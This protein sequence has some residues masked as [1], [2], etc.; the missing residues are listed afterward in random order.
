[1][2]GTGASALAAPFRGLAPFGESELDALLFFG[3][4]RETEVAVANLLAA[5]LTILY[6]PSGVGKSSLLR[7]GV[8]RRIRELSGHR[9][10]GRGPDGAAVV[11]ASW[12]DEPVQALADAIESEVTSL[13]KRPVAGPPPGT[14]L[15]DVVEHWSAVLDGRLYLVLDQLEEYFVYHEGGAGPGS[16]EQELPEVVLRSRL[17]A[18]VLLSLRDDALAQLDV[19][20]AQLPNL[21]AN[22]LRLDR[23]DHAAATAAILGPVKR[24]NELVPPGERWDVEPELV[25]DVLVQAAVTGEPDRIEPPYLQLVMERLWGEEHARGSR[26]LRASTLAELGGAGAIVREHLDRAM[27]VLGELEQ[28]AAAL[29][30][31]HLVTPSGTKVAHRAADLA[32]FAHVPRTEVDGLLAT[33]G[34]ERILRPLDDSAVGGDRYEIFHDVLG[35]AILGWRRRYQ[36]ASERSRARRRQRRLAAI[37]L[38]SLAAVLVMVGVTVYALT[39][40]AHARH[41]T[42]IALAETRLGQAAVQTAKHKTLEAQRE[43]AAAERNEKK[44]KK[45]DQRATSNLRVARQAQQKY[46]QQRNEAQGLATSLTAANKSLGAALTNVTSARD[47]AKQQRKIA[48]EKA[49]LADRATR[50]AQRQTGYAESQR[51]RAAARGS[52]ALAQADFDLDPAKSVTDALAAAR[53]LPSETVP[54]LR[55]ALVRLRLRRIIGRQTRSIHA[56]ALSPDSLRFVAAQGSDGAAVFD[57]RTGATIRRL[58]STG[59]VLVVAYAADGKTIAG[60]D[61]SG[62]TMLWDADSG[63]LLHTLPGTLPIAGLA[64]SNDGRLLATAG[65]DRTAKVWDVATGELRQELP[66]PNPVGSVAFSPDGSELLTTDRDRFARLFTL[67]SGRPPAILDQIGRVTSAQFSPDGSLIATTGLN[68][69]AVLWNGRTGEPVHTFTGHVS[70]VLDAAFSH[71]GTLLATASADN[72]ARI[73]GVKAFALQATISGHTGQVKSIAFSP[74][75]R[76]VV[77]GSADRTARIWESSDGF[78]RAELLGTDATVTDV[79][80]A[81]ADTVLTTGADGTARLWDPRD[82]PPLRFVGLH[83]GKAIA[84]AFALHGREIVSASE[85]GTAALWPVGRGNPIVLRHAAAVTGI[86]VSDDGRTILTSSSDGTAALWSAVTGRRL[87]SF[88]QGAPVAA[89]AISHDGSV[90]ATA[91]ADGTAKLWD[92]KVG[93]LLHSLP[94]AGPVDAVAFNNDGTLLVTGSTDKTARIWRVEDGTRVATLRHS[95]GVAAVAF[96]PDGRTVL[97]AA[98]DETLVWST[99]SWKPRYVFLDTNDVTSISFSRDGTR[100]LTASLDSTAQ[101]WD[102]SRGR[103]IVA[104]LGHSGPVSQAAFSADGRWVVTAGPLAAGVWPAM[105]DPRLPSNRLFFL[106]G[107]TARLLSVAFSPSG[108]RLATASI[109]GSIR[110]YNCTLCGGLAQLVPLARLRLRQLGIG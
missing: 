28:S 103:L 110:T 1:M 46:L 88:G 30:F 21:F 29:M 66:H 6:G 58:S 85:D 50:R 3:R 83:K 17:R 102:V 39:Q 14:S 24:W 91:G 73:W 64:F 86:T 53:I 107:N 69:T 4:E 62:N 47:S 9:A 13:V 109:D 48:L 34:R 8:A 42:A 108:W 7:A 78:E 76:F 60:G 97:A 45:A 96:S 33:L 80:F 23:L 68:R 15:A 99:L 20:K 25:E 63:A 104:L 12:A 36:L 90:V 54:V 93:A 59:D 71:D 31:D 56:V 5:R 70:N 77:T 100:V 2:T 16:F 106:G 75:D 101:V 72:T 94:S 27:S 79:V 89:A 82:Q 95:A 22:Y 43:K 67:A 32:T 44:F 51:R 52:L 81:S 61:R 37:A 19:F 40:R 87:M 98:G 41:Q 65:L 10:I 74:D 92:A 84:V 26:V 35:D 49:A 11:F 55:D 38:V 18:N 105:L 57:A